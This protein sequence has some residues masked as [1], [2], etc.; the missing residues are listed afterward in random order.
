MWTDIP[1]RRMLPPAVIEHLDIRHAIVCGCLTRGAITGRRPC[2]LSAPAKPLGNGMVQAL[3]LSAHP[4]AEPIVR[5]PVA[6]HIA[7][8]LPPAVRMVPQPW[9]GPPTA[10][11]PRS[12]MLDH[13]T[14]DAH[15]FAGIDI[16]PSRQIEP[17]LRCPYIRDGTRPGVLRLGHRTLTGQHLVGHPIPLPA[18]GGHGAAS[19]GAS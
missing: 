17:A 8:I 4:P 15:A 13:R 19:P 1:E 16:P 5:Q 14:F 3:P 10:P 7:G 12:R 2:A 9:R 6:R 11:R 18:V